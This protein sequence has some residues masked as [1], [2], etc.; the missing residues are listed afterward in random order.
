MPML[1]HDT[2]MPEHDDKATHSTLP[3]N[4]A[5]WQTLEHLKKLAENNMPNTITFI[6]HRLGKALCSS[7]QL[8]DK[9]TGIPNV[10]GS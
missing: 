10:E 6:P 1:D 4:A 3:T 9:R 8:K 7:L 5:P 2:E